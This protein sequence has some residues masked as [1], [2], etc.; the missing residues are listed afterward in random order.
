MQDSEQKFSPT[1]EIVHLSKEYQRLFLILP[2]A[3][4]D[5]N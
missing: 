3:T 2:T 5:T 4:G 1:A